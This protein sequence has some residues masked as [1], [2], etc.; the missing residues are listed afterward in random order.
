MT[1]TWYVFNVAWNVLKTNFYCFFKINSGNKNLNEDY[2]NN[3]FYLLMYF[4]FRERAHVCASEGEGQRRKER[5]NL[6]QA[7]LSV[8]PFIS[9]D[10]RSLRSWPKGKSR[11]GYL[12]NWATQMPLDE[13]YLIEFSTLFAFQMYF[14]YLFLGG[15]NYMCMVIFL[16]WTK[17]LCD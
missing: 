4:Y 3:Y 7:A 11:V 9:L 8:E 2:I 17:S 16:L 15:I 5:E 12:T 14:V 10:L 6:K 13:E 1:N